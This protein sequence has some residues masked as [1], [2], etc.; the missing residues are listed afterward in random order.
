MY[1]KIKHTSTLADIEK[2]AKLFPYQSVETDWDETEG[3][4]GYRGGSSN[5]RLD[6]SQARKLWIW[7]IGSTVRK[8]SGRLLPL[9]RP[10]AYYR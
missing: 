1:Y 3:L 7:V 4:Y 6:C 5:S 8:V 10:P 9:G 2:F